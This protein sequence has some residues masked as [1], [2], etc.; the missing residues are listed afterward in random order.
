MIYQNPNYY[1]PYAM[2]YNPSY[3]V[4]PVGTNS[5]YTIPLNTN[6]PYIH[7]MTQQSALAYYI[8]CFCSTSPYAM[9]SLIQ[10]PTVPPEASS[11]NQ[12]QSEKPSNQQQDG[13]PPS[14]VPQP[15]L[16][17]FNPSQNYC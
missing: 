14:E 12:Q 16:Y 6:Q 5:Q 17:T 1:Y 7:P 9:S 2:A 11:I 8:K 13:L 15:V 4:P 3:I 10:H